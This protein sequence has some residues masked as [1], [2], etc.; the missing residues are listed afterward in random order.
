[1]I[2]FLVYDRN[3]HRNDFIE[4][5]MDYFNWIR[6]ECLEYFHLDFVDYFG[7][8]DKY[9]M[10]SLPLFESFHPPDSVIYIIIFENSIAG[11]GGIKHTTDEF[12]EIKRIFIKP[13]FRGKGFGNLLMLK[14]VETAREFGHR[15]LRQDT[16]SDMNLYD[17]I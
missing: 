12:S 17:G 10:N 6:E 11:M 3:I 13:E 9:V 7:P 2:N 1:M 8:V 4:M 14:L 16:N 5:G 15:K